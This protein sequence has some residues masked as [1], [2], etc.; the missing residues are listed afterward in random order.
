[1]FEVYG[2][3]ENT[4]LGSRQTLASALEL[5]ARGK[6]NYF[7]VYNTAEQ[8]WVNISELIRELS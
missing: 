7:Y 5:G 4:Y 8:R 1:M 6:S 2:G 3:K